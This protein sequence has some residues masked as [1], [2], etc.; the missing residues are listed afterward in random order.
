MIEIKDIE[1]IKVIKFYQSTPYSITTFVEYEEENYF[2]KTIYG[3]R[4]E[5]VDKTIEAL[6]KFQ[7]NEDKLKYPVLFYSLQK[8]NGVMA[9][10]ILS[11]IADFNI[12]QFS[13]Q[14]MIKDKKEEYRQKRLL[15]SKMF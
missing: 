12:F 14:P 2:M 7:Q 10:S 11:E 8:Y 6:K 1:T 13:S 3:N 15:A 9:V 5:D 4:K